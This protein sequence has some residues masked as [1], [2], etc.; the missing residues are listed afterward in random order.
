MV[1]PT[2]CSFCRLTSR[3]CDLLPDD[4]DLA[5]SEGEPDMRLTAAG[6]PPPVVATAF[7]RVVP[8]PVATAECVSCGN[9][10]PGMLP[11]SERLRRALPQDFTISIMPAASHSSSSP[12]A[13]GMVAGCCML[14]QCV[15]IASD[16]H[17]PLAHGRLLAGQPARMY[18]DEGPRPGCTPTGAWLLGR[19]QGLSLV[20]PLHFGPPP[21]GASPLSHVVF[22]LPRTAAL[23]A[24]A[25]AV[26][27][28]LVLEANGRCF[29]L[30]RTGEPGSS[31]PFAGLGAGAD[32]HAPARSPTNSPGP[33]AWD[34]PEEGLLFPEAFRHGVAA[35]PWFGE[36]VH[37]RIRGSPASVAR[38]WVSFSMRPAEGAG[39][40]PDLAECMG[41]LLL[42]CFPDGLVALLEHRTTRIDGWH[43]WLRIGLLRGPSGEV[44]TCGLLQP[45]VAILLSR[46]LGGPEAGRQVAASARG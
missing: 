38:V 39:P 40:E 46:D 1:R 29:V 8:R 42:R 18:L 23:L 36:N 24:A 21:R 6:L 41:D 31:V 19:Q 30:R 34:T 16:G 37:I 45:Q 44:L 4:P 32:T 28:P 26:D 10:T 14:F 15:G 3:T 9:A 2:C 35:G 25:V 33:G 20:V 7:F 17:F 22:A 11:A 27:P 12:R 13:C 5:F 43:V